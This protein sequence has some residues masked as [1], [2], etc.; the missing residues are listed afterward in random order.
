MEVSAF[1][2]GGYRLGVRVEDAEVARLW[3]GAEWL[4]LH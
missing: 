2:S 4:R 1:Q 3:V